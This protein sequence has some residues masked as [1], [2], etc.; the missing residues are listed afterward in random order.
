M[1]AIVQNQVTRNYLPK[2]QADSSNKQA[3]AAGK[4]SKNEF[5]TLF[6]KQLEHQDPLNPLDSTEFTS[7]LAQFTSLEQLYNIND[8]LGELA[9]ASAARD[10]YQAVSLIGKKVTTPGQYLGVKGGQLTN[11]G[12]YELQNAVAQI[13]INIYD[14]NNNLIKVLNNSS[15]QAG[16]H[17][18]DWDG[19]DHYG[20][21]APDGI[22]RFEAIAENAD[23][24]LVDVNT[25]MKGKITGLTFDESGNPVPL[26]NEISFDLASIIQINETKPE[27]EK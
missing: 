3:D 10:N 12:F 19:T 24:S 1:T 17:K 25:Y 26:M 6:I 18:I 14:Q 9:K 27:E 2:Y 5:L 7:Q 22:Y 8:T 23:G 21:P 15:S 4:L 20:R 13:Q 16:D 11:E